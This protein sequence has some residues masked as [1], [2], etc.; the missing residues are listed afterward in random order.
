MSSYLPTVEADLVNF[1]VN[2]NTRINATPTAFGLTAIQS[3]AYTVLHDDFIAAYNLVTQDPVTRSTPNITAKNTAKNALINDPNGI[4]DLVDVIQAYA[5]TTDEQRAQLLIT[6][7]D[8]TPTPAPIPSD[9]PDLSIVST[10]GQNVKYRLR[11]S[12]NPNSRGKPEGVAGAMF[13]Y[14]VGETAPPTLDGWQSMGNFGKNVGSLAF[15]A[16]TVPP[17]SKVWLSAAWY[18]TRNQAGPLA[19]PLSFFLPGG[20]SQAA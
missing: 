13:F 17:G 4:R 1:S 14:Y 5:G 11:D 15:S 8:T 16:A 6:I 7:R 2:F 20:L 10:L 19:E 3:A 9:P 12:A 18:N